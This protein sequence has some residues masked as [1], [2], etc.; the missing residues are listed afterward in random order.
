MD[1]TQKVINKWKAALSKPGHISGLMKSIS[2]LAKKSTFEADSIHNQV[3]DSFDCLSCANCCK[4]IPPIV[5][6]RDAKRISRH[7][8][9]SVAEFETRY[10]Q[11]DSDG[12]RVMN[13]SPCPFLLEDNR[14]RIYLVRPA[15]CKTYPHSGDGDFFNHLNLHK[16][17][18]KYCPALYEIVRS[19]V[20][21]RG[22]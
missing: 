6:R 21:R 9:L 11:R 20:E 14:C 19:L 5:S 3:F 7:L 1:Q 18:A 16:R 13:Q 17:N 4:S 8:G 12:D 10:L 15:A 22:V 2:R